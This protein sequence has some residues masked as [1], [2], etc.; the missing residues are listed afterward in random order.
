MSPIIR[1]LVGWSGSSAGVVKVAVTTP[2]LKLPSRVTPAH[3]RRCSYPAWSRVKEA[4]VPWRVSPFKLRVWVAVDGQGS[5]RFRD[6]AGGPQTR[7]PATRLANVIR[8][9]VLSQLELLLHRHGTDTWG[10]SLG[11]PVASVDQSLLPSA[12]VALTRTV[13]SQPLIKDG[14]VSVRDDAAIVLCRVDLKLWPPDFHCRVY[15]VMALPPLLGAS[16]V[17][18]SSALPDAC[19]S[20]GALGVVLGVPVS[21][22]DGA[23]S[24]T[25]FTASTRTVYWVPLVSPVMV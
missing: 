2:E 4:E 14:T 1:T 15:T 12:V 17:T 8:T 18:T 13:Y 7:F 10:P 25:E 3:R 6:R 24:P 20:V 19:T 22:F 9:W 16:Q 11:V 21:E 23:L 5:L